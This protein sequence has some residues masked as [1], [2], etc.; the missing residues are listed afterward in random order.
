MDAYRRGQAQRR[1][2]SAALRQRQPHAIGTWLLL[3]VNTVIYTAMAIDAGRIAPFSSRLLIAW[4]A[5]FAPEVAHGE[6]WRLFTATFLHVNAVHLAVNM[7]A[8]AMVGPVVERLVGIRAF[9][10]FYLAS[11]LVGAAASL[12]VHPLTTSAGASGSIIGLYGVLLVMM[13]ERR[14]TPPLTL[15]EQAPF[16]SRPLLHGHLQSAV[17]LIAPTLL[18]GWFDPRADNAAHIGG[19]VAGCLFGWAGG[20]RI[21]WRVPTVRVAAAAAAIAIGCCAVALATQREVTD[22]RPALLEA[23][24]VDSRATAQIFAARQIARRQRHHHAGD[25]GRDPARLLTRAR[26]ARRARPGPCRTES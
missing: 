6:W 11:G 2:L 16:V 20:R 15:D 24:T 25:S 4:G 12:W 5:L 17:S 10:A 18:F 3:A 14:R 1:E 19:F 13:F 7:V 9:L 22:V 26:E 21:E 8:L 23:F